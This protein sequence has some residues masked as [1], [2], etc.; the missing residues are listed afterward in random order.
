MEKL[1]TKDVNVESAEILPKEGSGISPALARRTSLT[2]WV[3]DGLVATY[4]FMLL[5]SASWDKLQVHLSAQH[6]GQLDKEETS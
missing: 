1:A 4:F 5:R 3:L 6:Q 2:I